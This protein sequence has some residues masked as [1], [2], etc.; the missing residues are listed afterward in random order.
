MKQ[1]NVVEFIDK[2]KMISAIVTD[3]AE[4]YLTVATEFGKK[5]NIDSK[6]VAHVSDCNT[7]LEDIAE[8]RK[9]LA[10]NIDVKKIWKKLKTSAKW[11]EISEIALLCFPDAKEIENDHEAAALKALFNSR[12]YFKFDSC[13]FFPNNAKKLKEKKTSIKEREKKEELIEQGKEWIEK[14]IRYDKEN[15]DF[16]ITGKD[17]EKII[18]IL[19]SY[20]I[21]EKKSD[22]HSIAKSILNFVKIKENQA[23]FDLFVKLGIWE[24][25]ENIDIFR[26][27]IPVEFAEE[28]EKE[29]EK[30]VN[31]QEN[32]F[33]EYKQSRKDLT[34]LRTVTIDGPLTL[35]FDDSISIEEKDDE[36]ILGVHI[37]DAGHFIKKGSS[38]DKEARKRSSSIYM[39][40]KIIP[41][42]PLSLAE[43]IC[44]LKEGKISY[45]ISTLIR[46]D[47]FFNIKSYE[48]T[49]SAVEIKRRL[50]YSDANLSIDT[51]KDM[52][53]F[54]NIAKAFRKKRFDNGA[55]Q[56]T[57]PEI[58]LIIDENKEVI[59][60]TINRESPARD[61]FCFCLLDFQ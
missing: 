37:S 13:K 50:T 31:S 60:K 36:Y 26:Y 47:K 20:Y 55:I 8:K 3:T 56:I 22:H 12:V 27:D 6:R 51:D 45:A 24:K 18:D 32:I 41:M 43:G 35:D 19:K 58:T 29:T 14:A 42:L 49:P 21:F 53:N 17:N 44:S 39:P 59:F 9:K 48:V 11:S 4:Q 5:K 2:T 57:L 38:I 15:P 1:G 46:L 30:I 61:A 34:M 40:N 10:E 54:Y 28:T 7:T 16:S 25:D 52:T 23:I 33:Y